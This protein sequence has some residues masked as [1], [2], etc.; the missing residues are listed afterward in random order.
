MAD[1]ARPAR[2]RVTISDIAERS[3]VS[4]SAVSF[5]L[6]GRK[7][8]SAQTRERVLRVADELGWAPSSAARSLMGARTDTIGLVLA[9]ESRTLGIESFYMQFI[10]GIESELSTRDN[11]LLLQVVPDMETE[12]ATYKKWRATR[13]VDGIVMVD[14]RIDDPRI[15]MLS[16]AD[17]L[18]A[19]VVGD[20]S[21]AGGLPSVWTDDDAATRESLRYLHAIGHRRIA[22]VAGVEEFG[23]TH[24]RDLAFR[25]EAATLGIAGTTVRTDYMPESGSLVTRRLLTNG[26]RPTAIVY[27][28][29]VM[30][31]AGLGVAAELGIRVPDELSI[32]AWDDSPLCVAAYPRLSALNHD[33]VAYGAHVA[34]RLFDR[35]LGAEG[36]SFQDSTPALVP[37]G[38]TARAPGLGH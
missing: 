35:M 3:G 4:I 2:S 12:L 29:D 10:A 24:I 14:P 30:A 17:A 8:V 20:T 9:R 31:L 25:D 6:N 5:A 13:R 1:S 23:H 16:E 7:G 34:R 18:P 38:T 37:R 32:V 22:R 33:V 21:L 26:P 19:V 36:G 27:D 11:A 15:A 28:N